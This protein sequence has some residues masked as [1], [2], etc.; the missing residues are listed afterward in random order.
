MKPIILFLAFIFSG[1]LSPKA[2]AQPVPGKVTE[3]M[4]KFNWMV[5]DWKGEAWYMGRDQQ[6]TQ[7]VQREHIITRLDG[8]IITM[9]GTGYNIP[10]G[11]QSAKIVFQAFGIL[12]YDQYNSKFVLRAYN[13]G[14]FTDSDLN[15]NP[16]GSF[17]WGFDAGNGKMR[18]TL[19]LTPDG[20]W[21]ETGEFSGDGTTWYKT[22]EMTLSK[23]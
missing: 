5:G 21:N 22:F 2:I 20:K 17:S 7:I 14:N 6:K 18:Y 9:E 1:M 13:G 15:T 4:Q 3:Q 16:D 19:K 11:T 23:T 8:T 10:E 12:T